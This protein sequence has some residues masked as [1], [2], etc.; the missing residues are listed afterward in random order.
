MHTVK[1]SFGTIEG[2]EGVALEA[3]AVLASPGPL[4]VVTMGTFPLSLIAFGWIRRQK[5]D[6]SLTSGRA[7]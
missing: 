4:S 5:S 6:D 1:T 3:A 2:N 7:C